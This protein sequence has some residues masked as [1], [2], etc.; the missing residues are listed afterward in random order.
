[1]L[2]LLSDVKRQY[3]YPNPGYMS[4]SAPVCV[5]YSPAHYSKNYSPAHYSKNAL[6]LH[7]RSPWASARSQISPLCEDALGVVLD[8]N[9]STRIDAAQV[10]VLAVTGHHFPNDTWLAVLAL[11][12]L[13]CYA[14]VAAVEPH[15]HQ[16][17]SPPTECSVG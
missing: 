8:L 17:P 15:C 9:C 4:H 11:A 3:L 1:M 6:T 12:G 10:S 5:L 2:A 7:E 16:F 13:H 14:A